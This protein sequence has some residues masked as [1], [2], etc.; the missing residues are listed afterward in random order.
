MDAVFAKL[1]LTS[2]AL[3]QD[4]WTIFSYLAA[5]A[6]VSD[7]VIEK[8]KQFEGKIFATVKYDELCSRFNLIQSTVDRILKKFETLGWVRFV[9]NGVNL[10]E[11]VDKRKL[12]YCAKNLDGHKTREPVR[13][14]PTERLR[15]AVEEAKQRKVMGN[16]DKLSVAHKA[17]ILNDLRRQHPPTAAARVLVQIRNLY[18]RKFNK[19]YQLAADDKT[20]KPS[21]PKELRFLN[22]ALQYVDNDEA[23]FSEIVKWVFDNWDQVQQRL[24]W[25]GTVKSSL[26]ATK[27]C[28]TEVLKLKGEQYARTLTVGQ[29][30]SDVSAGKAK[31]EGF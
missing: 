13:E 22:M 2:T 20:G 1:L 18:V 19:H 23:K 6:I 14:T 17:S 26:F 31:D 10:G 15:R 12:W 8:Q 7:D 24:G 21:Y 27:K 3:L 29:R 16:I 4:E 9:D 25:L 11:W 5:R 28:F 30:Y